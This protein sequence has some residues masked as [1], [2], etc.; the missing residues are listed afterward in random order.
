MSPLPDVAAVVAA[1]T[2]PVPASTPKGVATVPTL[3]AV[4]LMDPPAAEV[5]MAV[6]AVP[7]V[8]ARRRSAW[9][10]PPRASRHR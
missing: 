6:A 2:V 9:R 1:V 10:W 8:I 7:P 3:A 5:S 4:R